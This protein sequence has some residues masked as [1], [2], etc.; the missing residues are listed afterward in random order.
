MCVKRFIY[1]YKR[2]LF[3]LMGQPLAL[4]FPQIFG[5]TMGRNVPWPLMLKFLA[6]KEE[7]NWYT[8]WAIKD[9]TKFIRLVM[10]FLRFDLTSLGLDMYQVYK[11]TDAQ[12][13]E[14]PGLRLYCRIN[15]L[16]S[17]YS[18]R[19]RRVQVIGIIGM[20]YLFLFIMGITLCAFANLLDHWVN[21]I[22]IGCV[23]SSMN[24]TG[25]T[26][27]LQT[28]EYEQFHEKYLKEQS[29]L[30]LI[31]CWFYELSTSRKLSNGNRFFF[32]MMI[33]YIFLGRK[34]NYLRTSN[35]FPESDF[36]NVRFLF[37]P[38]L[39]IERID[40]FIKNKLEVIE[41]SLK[42]Y[43]TIIAQVYQFEKLTVEMEEM[44]KHMKN[45]H[46]RES[47]ISHLL[48]TPLRS[49]NNDI[50][51]PGESIC[52]ADILMELCDTFYEHTKTILKTSTA[53]K[54]NYGNHIHRRR[55]SLFFIGDSQSVFNHVSRF[56]PTLTASSRESPTTSDSMNN[57]NN[58]ILARLDLAM[59]KNPVE[60][61]FKI[62]MKMTVQNLA[63]LQVYKANVHL[64]RPR[65][66]NQIWHLILKRLCAFGAIFLTL[67]Y[68]LLFTVII[69][70]AF[71]L[72]LMV[73]EC[74]RWYCPEVFQTEM[75]TL[76]IFVAIH[77]FVTI[78]TLAVKVKLLGV[79]MASQTFNIQALESDMS[80]C[81]LSLRHL[82]AQVEHQDLIAEEQGHQQEE[83]IEDHQSFFHDM[84][85]TQHQNEAT[86]SSIRFKADRMIFKCYVKLL[87]GLFELGRC[88]DAIT[89]CS[90]SPMALFYLI[91]LQALICEASGILQVRWIL[92]VLMFGGWLGANLLGIACAHYTSKITKLERLSWC[93]LSENVSLNHL[94]QLHHFS[95]SFSS[96]LWSRLVF[97][98]N[99]AR[100][101]YSPRPFNI[102]LTYDRILEQNFLIISIASIFFKN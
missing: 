42:F 84:K 4:T 3:L 93:I 22:P 94:Q 98:F 68:H 65:T 58:S 33:Y 19:D 51:P 18:T 88:A 86:G 83:N 36:T 73:S 57:I 21:V 35:Q 97:S 67:I 95:Q 38:K 43:R 31:L 49:I 96:E 72:A 74:G 6:R 80:R 28:R 40:K 9:E 87:V 50:N 62:L 45:D 20:I 11:L 64:V 66:Y 90:D 78:Q 24:M 55:Q 12:Y 48:I 27:Q 47:L 79:L 89:E 61:E 52:R 16:R 60:K 15:D 32:Y 85:E 5:I 63:L 92:W 71:V 29:F 26:Y 76:F 69:F 7:E 17:R 39:E 37:E 8:K 91:V 101:Q 75:V 54:N 81:L 30:G 41:S 14:H 2:L 34:V 25:S 13:R 99:H 23:V 70:V 1:Y 82:G 77:I 56:K 46:H 44:K 53:N 10:A 59:K 102:D 100:N